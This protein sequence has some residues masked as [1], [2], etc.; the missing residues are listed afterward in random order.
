MILPLFTMK[1]CEIN[2]KKEVKKVSELSI[3]FVKIYGVQRHCK[4]FQVVV[5]TFSVRGKRERKKKDQE[6]AD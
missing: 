6:R 5:C 4:C 2:N 1:N 3:P